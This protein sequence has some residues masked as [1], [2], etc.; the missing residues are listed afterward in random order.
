MCLEWKYIPYKAKG[1]NIEGHSDAGKK[2]KFVFLEEADESKDYTG[3]GKYG[4]NKRGRR[5][6]RGNHPFLQ[7]RKINNQNEG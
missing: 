7:K 4:G 6:S 5:I 3:Q 1:Y 2:M